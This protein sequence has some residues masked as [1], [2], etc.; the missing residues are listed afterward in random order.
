MCD[1]L[2]LQ[3]N[4]PSLCENTVFMCV[5]LIDPSQMLPNIKKL[6]EKLDRSRKLRTIQAQ[7]SGQFG[8]LPT[9]K[10]SCDTSSD[11]ANRS[12]HKEMEYVVGAHTIQ[13]KETLVTSV[14]NGNRGG[15]FYTK[16][17][18]LASRNSELKSL[19]RSNFGAS[20]SSA[21]L[22][23]G[24]LVPINK[25]ISNSLIKKKFSNL[26]SLQSHVRSQQQETM[27]N[28]KRRYYSEADIVDTAL[29]G[30]SKGGG[31]GKAR[32]T[33]KRKISQILGKSKEK[34][35]TQ[36]TGSLG[37]VQGTNSSSHFPRFIKEHHKLRV[38]EQQITN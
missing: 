5:N 21:S 27:S 24:S 6:Q 17:S 10:A 3:K 33:G 35:I 12:L 1:N 11:A 26:V 31:V 28:I 34:L 18:N 15:D 9:P 37:G 22:N 16:W 20:E 14:G 4:V 7:H 13:S 8:A 32:V 29:F 25:Q 30:L 23:A 2:L 19:I 36:S 38:A